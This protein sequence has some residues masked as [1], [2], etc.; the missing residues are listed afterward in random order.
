MRLV[1][2]SAVFLRGLKPFCAEFYFYIQ[3]NAKNAEGTNVHIMGYMRV[4]SC[5][6]EC[7][8]DPI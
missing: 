1:Y 5:K 8:S 4:Q 2:T 7:T 6:Q 3:A